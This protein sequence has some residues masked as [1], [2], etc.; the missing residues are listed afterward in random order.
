[1]AVIR[2]D[3]SYPAVSAASIIAKVARDQYMA[4][5]AAQY[6][7]YGFERHVGYGTARHIVA[8]QTY[9]VTAIHRQS[10]K[11]IQALLKL[12]A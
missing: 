3:D 2:A 8:L 7:G 4:A 1:M 6:P 10:Y 11:P 12:N 5:A 9:G